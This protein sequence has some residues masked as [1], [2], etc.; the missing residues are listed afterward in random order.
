MTIIESLLIFYKQA[1]TTKEEFDQLVPILK[2]KLPE[3]VLNK[4]MNEDGL[5]NEDN[6][7]VVLQ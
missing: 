5:L 1:S 6:D 4:L 2:E 7:R 3:D